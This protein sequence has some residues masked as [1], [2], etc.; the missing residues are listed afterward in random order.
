MLKPLRE[1]KVESFKGEA[2]PE[3]EAPHES[4]H[5]QWPKIETPK[6]EGNDAK[7]LE[8]VLARNV[9]ALP[10]RRRP[11]IDKAVGKGKG[12]DGNDQILPNQKCR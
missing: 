2:P 12:K 4:D 8:E 10:K 11:K 1:A 9:D 5:Q 3:G 6:L 7:R